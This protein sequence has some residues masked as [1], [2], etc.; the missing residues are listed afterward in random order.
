[1]KQM[2]SMLIGFFLI[3][4]CTNQ[5]TVTVTEFSLSE[6]QEELNEYPGDYCSG[7]AHVKAEFSITLEFDHEG[8]K[9]HT[10]REFFGVDCNGGDE[11]KRVIQFY[12]L[13]EK[14][15]EQ[16]ERLELVLFQNSSGGVVDEN[17]SPKYLI[18]SEIRIKKSGNRRNSFPVLRK[19]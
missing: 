7:P 8:E 11:G 14:Q 13:L 19:W 10:V 17:D 12:H 1:M 6:L 9:L 2:I 15:L 3:T 4:S 18:V 5:D 16:P